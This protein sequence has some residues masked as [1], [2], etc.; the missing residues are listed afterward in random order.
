[1]RTWD[2]LSKAV[3]DV[4]QQCVK[5]ESDPNTP[6]VE[7]E[8]NQVRAVSA[9]LDRAWSTLY[10][11]VSS[12]EIEPLAYTLAMSLDAWIDEVD[13]FRDSNNANPGG[14]DSMWKAWR[15]VVLL[16]KRKPVPLMLET[17]DYLVKVQK[18]SPIQ[19]AKIYEWKDEFGQPD[20]RRVLASLEAGNGHEPVVS[21][22]WR[23]E[24]EKNAK[25]WEARSARQQQ[26]IAVPLPEKQTLSVMAPESMEMLLEQNVPSRQIAR[27]K[28]VDQQTVIDY[29]RE[30]GMTVDGQQ[31]VPAMTPDQHLSRVRN[32]ENERL[33]EARA[34]AA[35]EAKGDAGPNDEAPGPDTYAHLNN[36]RE[37]VRQMAFD[38]RTKQEIVQALKTQYPDKA[39]PGSVAQIISAISRE[40]AATSDNAE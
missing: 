12:G 40:V 7:H 13:R 27:M 30:L 25:L 5:W 1:M 35:K 2:E 39:K 36:Y 22:H 23:R 6:L 17:I 38:N 11:L 33:A 21:P 20:A 3:L 8:L 24:C 16:A 29:A 28:N 14:T 4:E 19:V 31:P 15:E 9:K 18:C 32:S 10:D 34:Y 37:Q 26:V